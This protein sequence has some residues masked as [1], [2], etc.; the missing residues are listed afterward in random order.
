VRLNNALGVAF[1]GTGLRRQRIYSSIRLRKGHGDR[2]MFQLL[3]H[4]DNLRLRPAL[5]QRYMLMA[6]SSVRAECYPHLGRAS[7]SFLLLFFKKEAFLS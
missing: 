2:S 4:S 7:K 3:H 5:F 1:A 6:P